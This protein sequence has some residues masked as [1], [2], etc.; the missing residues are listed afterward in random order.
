L[1]GGQLGNFIVLLPKFK[2]I[3]HPTGVN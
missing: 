2:Q 3:A 1:S